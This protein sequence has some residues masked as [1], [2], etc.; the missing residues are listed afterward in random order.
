MPITH[1]STARKYAISISISIGIAI[2][3]EIEK[4]IAIPRQNYTNRD[5]HFNVK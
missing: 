3:I 2:G 4:S 1:K 5:P